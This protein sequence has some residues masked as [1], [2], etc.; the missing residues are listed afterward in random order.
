M[1]EKKKSRK[2]PDSLLERNSTLY[3]V[4]VARL[5]WRGLVLKN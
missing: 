2:V 3:E 4:H 5:S 1:I